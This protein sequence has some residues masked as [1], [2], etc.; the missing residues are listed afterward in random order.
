MASVGGSESIAAPFIHQRPSK[1]AFILNPR[2]GNGRAGRQWARLDAEIARLIGEYT[3]FQTKHPGHATELTRQ[4]LHEGHD[5]IV[6]AGGDGT[7]Y[8]VVNGFFDGTDP[9]NPE[10]SMALL[11]IGTA[12]DLCKTYRVPKGRGA[13]PFLNSEKVLPV[14][15]G[16]LTSTTEEGET[17]VRHFNTAAHIGLGGVVG[18][19]TNRRSK[20]LGGFLTFLIGVITARIEYSAKE[21]TVEC[22]GETFTDTLME[23]VVANGFYDGGGMHVAPHGLLDSGFFEVYTMAE[24]G[25]VDS[26]INIP[27]M[28]KG[29]QDKHPAVRY[30]RAKRV[31]VTSNERVVVSPDGE[32]AGVLP[33][34]MEI[35]PKALRIVTGPDPRV[36]RDAAPAA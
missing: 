29:T 25:P 8:E 3:V 18:E 15:V 4:A 12:S 9:I 26:L 22:D 23:V 19:H 13:I 30:R 34:T 6:S 5:R 20:A 17:I 16:R 35:V 28:Y 11:A 10:A 2:S 14:D 1:Y 36:V 31:T 32:L 21:M 7:H 33:A 24:M 27:R